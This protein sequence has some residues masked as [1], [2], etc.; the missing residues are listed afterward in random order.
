MGAAASS[1]SVVV[2]LRIRRTWSPMLWFVP[3]RLQN[4][5]PKSRESKQWPV[6]KHAFRREPSQRSRRRL[7][8]SGG[9]ASGM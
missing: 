1:S 3:V 8:S 7:D 5:R 4:G 2:V 6:V 9:T